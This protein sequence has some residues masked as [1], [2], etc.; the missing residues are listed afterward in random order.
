MLDTLHVNLATRMP[1]LY[2]GAALHR[3]ALLAAHRGHY[4]L[5]ERLFEHAAERYREVLAVERLARLRVHQLIARVRSLAAP[6]RDPERCLEVERM[7]TH[8][9]RIEALEPPFAE[10]DA[11]SLLATWM[12]DATPAPAALESAVARLA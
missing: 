12:R 2:R 6:D 5:A 9:D 1:R 10:V 8:L 3:M 4:D 7:L 11:R